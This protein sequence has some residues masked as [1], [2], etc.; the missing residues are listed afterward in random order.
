MKRFADLY[1]ALDSSNRN[2]DKLQSIVDYLNQVPPEDAAWAVY[3]LLG[4]RLG[5]LVS[6]RVL[7]QTVANV[8]DLP[9]WL[10]EASYAQVGDL[11]ETVALLLPDQTSNTTET[12][13][14]LHRL[15]E[16]L[17]GGLVGAD[18]S[19]AQDLLTILWQSADSNER[20]VLNKLLT[21]G[22]RVGV[23]RATVIKALAQLADIEPAVMAHRIMGGFSPQAESY[24]ALFEEQSRADASARPY[25]FYLANPIDE[26]CSI[27]ELLGDLDE[28]QIEWKWDGIRA[29]L[30]RRE[31]ASLLWSRGE[32]LVGESFPEIIDAVEVLPKG[33]VLDGELLGWDVDRQ[34]PLPFAALQQRL[35]RKRISKELRQSVPVCFMAYDLLE[36]EGIDLREESTLK[37]RERMESLFAVLGQHPCLCLSPIV[38]ASDWQALQKLRLKSRQHGVEG[39]MIK[40]KAGPYRVGRVRGDWW[41]WKVDPFTLD[42]VL[43][44]AVQGHGRRAGL[45]TDYTFALL[46]GAQVWVPF[47][48]AYS[49]LTD[50]EIRR[51]DAWIRRHTLE[52]H[53]PVRIVEPKLVFEIAFEGVAESRR[54]KCGL[55]VR[56]PRIH[57]W[58]EDKTAE[59]ADDLKALRE[60][61]EKQKGG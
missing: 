46:D 10:V 6:G 3:F 26:G 56:F 61:L 18:E 8:M 23:S 28:W 41:K 45:Y 48:K 39:F 2:R 30:L 19:S 40:R 21:G 9:E 42:A 34:R 55:A 25:P 16:R 52:R 11:A 58:R 54:H 35:G 43:V 29:Q 59:E 49:G 27:S 36:Y 57:R 37:R 1:F 38:E 24:L 51:V 47:A 44:N 32:E 20:L 15:V 4:N 50:A 13:P 14:S 12:L 5:R 17:R 53:G 33:V 22:M 60:L 7:R 31:A